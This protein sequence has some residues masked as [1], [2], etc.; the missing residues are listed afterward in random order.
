MTVTI[1]SSDSSICVTTQGFLEANDAE[2]QIAVREPSLLGDAGRLA[3]ALVEYVLSSG[4]K[5]LP[6]QTVAWATWLLKFVPD[7]SRTLSAYEAD[8]EH[9]DFSHGATFTIQT[10]NAQTKVCTDNNVPYDAPAFTEFVVVAPGVLNGEPID[11]VRYPY[12][13]PNTGWWLFCPSYDG[14][15]NSVQ[16]IPLHHLYHH[17]TTAAPFLGL[18][19]GHCFDSR[20]GRVW[21]DS[22]VAKEEP[23]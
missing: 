6:N 15:V 23:M 10:W 13:R 17:N 7:G 20:S 19:P 8:V 1:I 5:I 2:L 12:Q 14:D 18:G 22:D 21:F 4:N 9:G 3:Q 16:R 11:G